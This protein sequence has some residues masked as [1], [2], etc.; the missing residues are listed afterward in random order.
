MQQVRGSIPPE[1]TDLLQML[2]LA[3]KYKIGVWDVIAF[4]SCFAFAVS[5]SLISINRFW[6]YEVFYYDFGIFDQAIWNVS[7]FSP[8][9]I[10]HF[11]AGGKWI[12][13][14]HFNPSIFL[15][16]PLYWITD[17]QEV[18]LIAQ[19][20]AVALSGL[21][22]YLIGRLVLKNKFYALSILIVYFL[23][24]GLQNAVITDFHEVTVATLP[25]TITFWALVKKK[26]KLFLLAFLITLGF[27]ESNFIL[28][29]G[30]GIA[31]FLLNR[32]AWKLAVVTCIISL[33][34]GYISINI[35]IPYFSGSS[36]QYGADIKFNLIQIAST[37]FDN[38]TKIDTLFSS[39]LSFGFLPIISYQFWFLIFQDFLIR[40]YSPLWVTRWGLSLHYSALLAAIFG[41]SSIFSLRLLQKTIKKKFIIDLIAIALIVNSI[42]VY[43]FKLHGPFGLA[44]NKAFYSHSNDFEFLN[45]MVNLVPDSASVMTTNNLAAHF[46]HQKVMLLRDTCKVC[47]EEY[48]Q[49]VRPQPDYLVIDNRPG[50]NPN[51]FFGVSKMDRILRSLEKDKGYSAIYKTDFQFVYKIVK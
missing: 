18:I 32:K 21:T 38:Q 39:F 12:F 14:D 13:A 23:F 11:V 36:Y 30:I 16:S 17:K 8:P 51:N 34:W 6:Q 25:L 1:S 19:A 10:E 3:K 43:H 45:R 47:K 40:F 50:Q 27:K 22:L 31:V 44:Y 33:V 4:F 5:G 35:I 49:M 46:T 7:R 2:R 48:Y 41:I 28:G 20:V 15:L 24:V 26:Y 9:I 42:Y 37:F 29:F